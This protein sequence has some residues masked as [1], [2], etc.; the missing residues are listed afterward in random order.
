M[1]RREPRDHMAFHIARRRA[2]LVV[3][4]LLLRLTSQRLIHASNGDQL[5]DAEHAF[6]VSAPNRI[7][8]IRCPVM[9]DVASDRACAC[10]HV[11]RKSR[12]DAETDQGFGAVVDGF[13]D[14]FFEPRGVSASR[15]RFHAVGS[16][17]DARLRAQARHREYETWLPSHAHIP[18]RTEFVLAAFKLRYRASA[19]SGKNFA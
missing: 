1:L 9:N 4:R 11:P 13:S 17:G 15:H 3:E 16:L 18:T 14:E 5:R 19:H 12:R 2:G 10:V 7:G 8:G 6:D